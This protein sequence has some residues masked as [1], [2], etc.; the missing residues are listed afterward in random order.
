MTCSHVYDT[1]YDNPLIKELQHR[2]EIAVK[3]IHIFTLW[4]FLLLARVPVQTGVP[5]ACGAQ[6]RTSN[7]P[8]AELQMTVGAETQNWLLTILNH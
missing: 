2:T 5:G 6:K 8:E 3:R 7:Q 1:R 4:T